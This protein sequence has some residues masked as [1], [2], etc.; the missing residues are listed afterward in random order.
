MQDRLRTTFST[1]A[2]CYLSIQIFLQLSPSNFFFASSYSSFVNS[3]LS[4]SLAS[5]ESSVPMW[6]MFFS[7]SLSFSFLAFSAA[8]NLHH[9]LVVGFIQVGDPLHLGP[10]SLTAFFLA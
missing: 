6:V 1:R 5:F 9:P 7:V 8:W 2:I 3:P 4:S 10:Y